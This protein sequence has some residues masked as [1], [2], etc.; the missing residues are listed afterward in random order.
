[1]LLDPHDWALAS[2][3][4]DVLPTLPAELAEHARAGDARLGARA[5]QRPARDRRARR[6]PSSRDLRAGLAAD[7][8]RRSSCAPPSAGT[9]P[10]AQWN[11]VEVSPGARYR[12][13][14]DSMRELARREPTFALHVHVAVPDAEAAIRALR[15]LRVHV[16]LLLALAANSPFWQGRDTGLASAR[17]PVFGTFPRVGIPRR[18][19]RLRAS[20]SRRSTCCCA[21][22]RSPS[23]RSCGGTCG[24][25]RSSA[26]SRCGSWTRRRASADNA[27][28]VALVQCA[29]RLEATRGLRRRGDRRAARG[30]RREPLPGDARRDAARSS[31][32]RSTTTRRPAR[33]ILDELLA[34]CGPHAA[35][36]GCEAELAGGARRSRRSRATTASGCSPASRRATRSGRA[37]ALV[38]ALAADFTGDPLPARPR[39]G[40]PG[41]DPPACGCTVR[42]LIRPA[43][44]AP[45]PSRQREQPRAALPRPAR[46]SSGA[47][48]AASASRAS[49]A[50]SAGAAA[51]RAPR[52]ARRRGTRPCRRARARARG[53]G[54]CTA[55]RGGRV[56]AGRGVDREPR[57]SASRGRRDV[58]V[59]EAPHE[60][61]RAVERCR[62]GRDDPPAGGRRRLAVRQRDRRAAEE[63]REVAERAVEPRAVELVDHEPAP[64][65]GGVDH[66]C[67]APTPRRPGGRACRG[68]TSGARR[69]RASHR[70]PARP[71]RRPSRPRARA[72]SCRSRPARRARRGRRRAPRRPR[73]RR[74][75]AAAGRPPRAAVADR[76]G[77]DERGGRGRRGRDGRR[78]RRE[79]RRRRGGRWRRRRRDSA[80]AARAARAAAATGASA[81]G[82]AGAAA[83][84]TGVSTAGGSAP[85]A[86]YAC[87]RSSGPLSHMSRGR[88]RR[89]GRGRRGCRR[90]GRVRRRPGPGAD[91]LVLVLL[92][93]GRGRGRLAAPR[94]GAA[95]SATG[96]GGGACAAANSASPSRAAASGPPGLS[97]PARSL[98]DMW[99]G[100]VSSSRVCCPV[101]VSRR[102]SSTSSRSR[103]E[104][105]VALAL[106]LE[107]VVAVPAGA[108][109]VVERAPEVDR[110]GAEVRRVGRVQAEPDR[111]AV[112][113]RVGHLPLAQQPPQPLGLRGRD[114]ERPAPCRP[115]ARSAC[116][117]PSARPSRDPR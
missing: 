19:R 61:G 94:P 20:T 15:G 51:L 39:A 101:A 47:M 116:P 65:R 17:V 92:L 31:S 40:A 77:G 111:G 52:S 22:A 16:P 37:R 80:L 44:G 60:R 84:G 32:T 91:V 117:S 70:R 106:R 99:I 87:V 85:I 104:R 89:P 57:A 12:S 59:G 29:V 49:V 103:E 2:R 38:C 28:L 105:R 86:W 36:L 71:A 48:C 41:A 76:G 25:S 98:S 75:R 64:A 13:I 93:R 46:P 34:A 115:R 112:V 58:D 96:A 88:R 73:R 45:R 109:E 95:G 74:P 97:C 26:R 7:A 50:S 42:G 56:A 113:D 55:A 3:I 35:A 5:V 114:V 33:D 18:V 43:C 83:A 6:S 108:A 54:A 1:M 81:V 24:C 9:H 79:L 66:D 90:R 4:D 27:A 69:S 107:R 53:A 102:S 10:F 30:A 63:R 62:R 82:A 72:S 23:R 100:S 110:R 68:P 67:R 14:Y 21:A 78:G 8:R 11:E